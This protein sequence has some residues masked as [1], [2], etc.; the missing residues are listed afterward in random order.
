MKHRIDTVDS[1]KRLLARRAPY[2]VRLSPGL[3]LGFR[4]MTSGSVGTWLA[5]LY[6]ESTQK[7]T[8]RSLGEFEEFQAH[9]RYGEAKKAAESLANHLQR[10]GAADSMTVAEACHSYI[11][12]QRGESKGRS[13]DEAERWVRKWIDGESI[14]HIDVR[15]LT[16]YH[17]RAW[18]QKLATADFVVNP[19]AE[20][21]I[22]RTKK[23][24]ASTVNRQ[25][26]TLRAA[27]NFALEGGIA[28]SDAAWRVALRPA[29]NAD[30]RRAG[31]LERDQRAALISHSEKE[32]SQFIKGLCLVPLRPGAMA[33]LTVSDFD[34][35][36]STLR[37]ST[38]K[39]GEGRSIKLPSGT[40]AFF[41]ECCDGKPTNAPIFTRGNG[42][43]WDKDTWK[44]PL[45]IAAA[46]AGLPDS[47][48]AYVLRHSVITDLITS[49]LDPLTVARLSGTSIAMIEKHY[50]HLRADHAASAL[51]G[52]A[53]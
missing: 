35:R 49:G 20:L 37:I 17:L 24:S 18:R 21:G 30:R 31:Y 4:K 33:A 27:L 11:K 1:R 45:K 53:M 6:D 10:G 34:E 23:R 25:I 36:L 52:L 16:A 7:E 19:H 13:V 12:H 44:K 9:E 2:W 29:V 48:T 41:L 14:G 40:A 50:G 46:A 38:D 47:T 26:T 43:F 32:F 5:R 42:K 51:A 22:Q 39:A 28:T 8:W 3:S 15:K